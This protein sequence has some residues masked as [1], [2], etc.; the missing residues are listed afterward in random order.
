MKNQNRSRLRPSADEER[1]IMESMARLASAGILGPVTLDAAT[2]KG[3]LSFTPEVHRLLLTGRDPL[4]EPG[5]IEAFLTGDALQVRAWLIA[6]AALLDLDPQGN[7]GES[8]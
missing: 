1:Q 8:K 6:E 4:R 2:G 5:F 7:K 3:V